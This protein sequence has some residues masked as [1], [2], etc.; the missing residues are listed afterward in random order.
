[1]F[2]KV[3]HIIL[4]VQDFGGLKVLGSLKFALEQKILEKSHRLGSDWLSSETSGVL[5]VDCQ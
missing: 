2:L 4:M 1:M 5:K 3:V